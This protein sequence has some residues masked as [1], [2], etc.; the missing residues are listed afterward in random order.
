MPAAPQRD[1][2]DDR[3]RGVEVERDRARPAPARARALRPDRRDAR[4]AT[5]GTRSRS[6]RSAPRPPAE[7]AL[8]RPDVGQSPRCARSHRSPT[9]RARPRSTGGRYACCSATVPRSGSAFHRASVRGGRRRDPRHVVRTRAV[10]PVADV[11]AVERRVAR[12][13]Q[14]RRA[15]SVRQ[16]HRLLEPH[17][18]V[19]DPRP[20]QHE[21]G[22]TDR[23]DA[24]Q[25]IASARPRAAEHQRERD[26]GNQDQRARR[27]RAP[28]ARARR[29]AA[30]CAPIVGCS[31]NRSTA[32]IAS[33]TA[34]A[35][36][37]SESNA[38][39]LSQ[40]CGYAAASTAAISPAR[41]PASRRPSSPTRPT[42]AAPSRHDASRCH[43][44]LL[45]P[46]ERPRGEVR[47]VQRRVRGA[48]ERQPRE[49]DSAAGRRS[50]C[51]SPAGSRRSGTRTRRPTPRC[52]AW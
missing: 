37:V 15:E 27:A 9:R 45:Q 42:V 16:Q 4:S 24:H 31:R 50:P 40:R 23:T 6:D 33:T 38:A 47:D 30:T 10:R 14:Q 13:A 25:P 11:G 44:A 19:A 51:P 43:S 41:S 49:L 34:N 29:R 18:V 5:A 1:E 22:D 39:S 28:R 48:R 3:G 32:S 35:A 2:P 8:V 7:L 20:D 52:A 12:T 26:R 36:A 46:D 21:R 17:E